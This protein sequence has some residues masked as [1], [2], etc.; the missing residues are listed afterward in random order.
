MKPCPKCGTPH[1]KPGTFCSRACANSRNHPPEV[2]E[3]MA[4]AL[5]VARKS[6]PPSE[7]QIAHLQRIA[8]ARAKKASDEVWKRPFETWP[9]HYIKQTLFKEQEGKCLSCQNDMWLGEPIPLELD[10]I[11]GTNTNNVRSNLRLLCP[12]CHAKTPTW[13][14][15]K[16]KTYTKRVVRPAGIEPASA[17]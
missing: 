1:E 6:K 11:D 10:H 13:R 12:N 3:K 9:R 17:V 2:Y 16:K 5:S 15:A 4:A 8:S 7:K 14:R